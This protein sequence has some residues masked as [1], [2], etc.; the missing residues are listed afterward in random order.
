M[1]K[2][3]AFVALLLSSIFYSGSTVHADTISIACGLALP[4]SVIKES[5]SGMELEIVQESLK[6]EGHELQVKFLPFKRVVSSVAKGQLDAALTITEASGN[7]TLFY[8]NTHI[9]YQNVA[10]SLKSNAFT[11]KSVS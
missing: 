8:S 7:K 11:V 6:L 2:Q 9:T 4:P 5:V 1:L 10:I 3:F